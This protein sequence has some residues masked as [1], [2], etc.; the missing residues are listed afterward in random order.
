ME[1]QPGTATIGADGVLEVVP[2]ILYAS[3]LSPHGKVMA[4]AKRFSNEERRIAKQR[5]AR[6]RRQKG[7]HR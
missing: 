5:Q 7:Q 3:R 2:G 6:K 4:S 1:P